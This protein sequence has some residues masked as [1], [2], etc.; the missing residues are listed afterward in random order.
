M[1]LCVQNV[2]AQTWI[3][4]PGDYEIWLGNEMNN[5]RTDRGAYF[6]PFWKQDSHYVTVEF[7]KEVEIAASE[8]ISI[9]V[10]GKYNVKIDGRMLFG[11]PKEVQLAPGRHKINIKVHNQATPP[12]L[13]VKGKEV[14]TDGTW[15]VTYEDKEWID[16]S[17]KAS[18]T[19]VSTYV[20]AGYWNF[21][22]ATDVPSRFRLK[23]TRAEA[24]GSKDG[25]YDF[26][27]ET[28][29][30]LRLDGVEGNGSIEIRYGESREEASDGEHCETLD[31]L[32]VENGV[33][34]DLCTGE[35]RRV[36][37][38]FVFGNSKAF[39]YVGVECSGTAKVQGVSMDYEY[40]PEV[41]RGT[42]S[43]SDEMVNKMWEIGVYTLQLT[44][45]EFFIDGIKRDRWVWSGDASQS[46]LMN[47]YLFNDNE[48]VKRT[49]W[50]LAGKQPITS[51]INTIMDYTLYWFISVWDYY[52]YSGDEHFLRQ[53]YPVM[54]AYIEFVNS[55]RDAD[56]MLQGLAGDWV[57]VDWADKPMDKRGQLSFEQILFV[58]AVESMAS[59]AK[60]IG[61]KGDA[62]KYERQ[63]RELKG[64]IKEFFWDEGKKAI[65]HNRLN[66]VK[67]EEVF[68]FSSIF[69][70]L[71]DTM[72][73]ADKETLKT[74]V[75]MNDDILKITT[76]Y[77]R[78]Y[79]M[80]ALC[81]LGEQQ[82][83][84]KEMKDYWGGMIQ[85]GAT[86]FW[87]KYNPTDSGRSHLQMYGRPYG[88][89]LCHAWGASPIYLLGR[90]FLGVS[91]TKPGYEEYEVRPSL[92]DLKW[93]E[94]DVPTPF[95]KVHVRMD[96]KTVS[97]KSDGGKGV[98]VI[99]GK[100][101]DIPVGKEIKI[102]Y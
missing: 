10:E 40:M 55:R 27:K 34:T 22:T 8:T 69:A 37:E 64:K 13:F 67:S 14:V 96:K 70:I 77:M 48:E 43:C 65:V 89:S 39:R 25:I 28:F 2:A 81:R 101:V 80:E 15:R 86:T 29:G 52:Q 90:Y 82:R 19:S 76:P 61:E 88:K 33:V 87:E 73:D 21:N 53:I 23:T 94:G 78:F 49:M 74:S 42:F 57:F 3:W 44:T 5:R 95:G 75:V 63:A 11:M 6:P 97:V 58:R 60:T 41:E 45:R 12:A 54:T 84:M 56:G 16:E 17:G 100:R 51:H 91:P 92:A 9:A 99:G 26:G 66:G 20:D 47:Y 30:Y 85:Q 93:M 1:S 62:E 102:K 46:Y 71:F 38:T 4:Y 59:V 7:S 98:L 18:D 50:L 31:R 32:K 68:K 36:G 24:I 72:T 35:E 83:V 79:E